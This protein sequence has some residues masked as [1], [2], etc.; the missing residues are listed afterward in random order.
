MYRPKGVYESNWGFG[1]T[2]AEF[3]QYVIDTYRQKGRLNQHW[4][5]YQSLCDPCALN[6][7]YIMKLE[8]LTADMND[9]KR[10]IYGSSVAGNVPPAYN[11]VTNTKYLRAY[12]ST[13]S[14]EQL[15]NISVIYNTDISMFSYL[16]LNNL[17]LNTSIY[18]SVNIKD[19]DIES[20]MEQGSM[21]I[22]WNLSVTTT[23]I[24]KFITCDLFSNVFNW[25]LMLPIY[26]Y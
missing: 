6:Y 17:Y 3:V 26:S 10:K 24:I 2:F 9:I 25:R 22:Q 13:L 1:V 5:T 14:W 23:F 18:S 19:D 8:T 16:Y 11:D 4:D 12:S 7:D 21:R 15:N 20:W